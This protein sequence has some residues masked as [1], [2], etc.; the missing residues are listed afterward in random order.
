MPAIT[1]T[2]DEVL[3]LQSLEGRFLTRWK[4]AGGLELERQFRFH[5]KRRFRFDFALVKGPFKLGIEI[6]GGEFSRVRGG[7]SRGM[8][9]TNDALKSNL[10]VT[11]GWRVLRFNTKMVETSAG[12]AEAAEW[13]RDEVNKIV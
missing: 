12:I 8:G 5:Q 10:A 3:F 2:R 6:D 9:Q 13:A 11:M 1:L 4:A 7:H